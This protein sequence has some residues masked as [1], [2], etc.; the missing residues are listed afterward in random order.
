MAQC[1]HRLQIWFDTGSAAE[2][3]FGTGAWC[4]VRSVSCLVPYCCACVAE[5]SAGCSPG[6][7]PPTWH[8]NGCTVTSRSPV[9]PLSS[10]ASGDSKQVNCGLIPEICAH[11]NKH[12][13][14]HTTY[15]LKRHL[16]LSLCF[17]P[18][19]YNYGFDLFV[20]RVVVTQKQYC[21]FN[22]WHYDAHYV[23]FKDQWLCPQDCTCLKSVS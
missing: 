14:E 15:S 19:L 10:S 23:S 3:W 13:H 8:E 21:S 16:S 9:N 7:F 18:S 5:Q 17:D 20:W 11:S 6:H 1:C 12:K 4:Y 22:W 2:V